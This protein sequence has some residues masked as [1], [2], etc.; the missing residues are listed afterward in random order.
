MEQLISVI[1]PIYN[2]KDC[3]PRCVHSVCAQTWKNIEILLVDDGST[4]G[5]AQL[6][7]EL[8][9]EDKRIR[10]FHKENGGS[11]SARNFGLN[12]AK[13][14]YVGFVDSDDWIDQTMYETLYHLM[15]KT[16]LPIAQTGRDEMAEDGSE[17]P[18]ICIPPEKDIIIESEDFLKELLMHQGDCS[19]CTKLCERSLFATRR[20]PEGILNEDFFLMIHMLKEIKGIASSH[21]SLYHVFYRIGSNTRKQSKDEFPRVFAD[22]VE[23]ADVAMQLVE[24]HFPK[25]MQQAFRFGIFQRLEYLLHIPIR[26][27]QKEN[28]EYKNVVYFLRKNYGKGIRSPYLSVK[29]KLYL[30]LFAIAPRTIRVLHKRI[31]GL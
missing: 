10:V 29:N 1:I 12:H 6:C 24:K 17:L 2:I 9:L 30:T 15:Q 19:F 16:G 3:L 31:R 5:T 20:F 28:I 22:C 26:F 13:G 18:L 23:N 8:A 21:K 7:D 14:D 4:D 27:M 11:S 25:L